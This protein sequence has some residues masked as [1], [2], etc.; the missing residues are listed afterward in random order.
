MPEPKRIPVL[1]EGK[2]E[3]AVLAKLQAAGLLPEVLEVEKPK[4][5]RMRGDPGG[6]EGLLNSLTV[7]GKIPDLKAIALRD[8]DDLDLARVKQWAEK[9]LSRKVSE[10]FRSVSIVHD[11]LLIV[12][13]TNGARQIIIPVGLFDD[14]AFN[15]KYHFTGFAFDDYLLRLSLHRAV[16]ENTTELKVTPYEKANHKLDEICDL[17][18]KNEMPIK[19]SKRFL[20]HLWAI[21]GFRASPAVMAEQLTTVALKNLGAEQVCGM[22]QPLIDDITAAVTLLSTDLDMNS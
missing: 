12:D 18:V 10:L 4:D 1:C 15:T 5:G 13:Y 7:F 2:E 19:R 20:L 21:T 3:T 8:M 9:D 11:R 6:M 14:D 22:F 16:Y 17:M